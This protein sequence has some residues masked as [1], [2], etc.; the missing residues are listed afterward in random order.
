MVALSVALGYDLYET[1][2]RMLY[3]WA[4]CTG[5]QSPRISPTLAASRLGATEERAVEALRSSLMASMCEDGDL[6]IVPSFDDT[7]SMREWW[8]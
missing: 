1:V 4:T 6:R 7:S 8:Q 5:Y 3:V 2:G